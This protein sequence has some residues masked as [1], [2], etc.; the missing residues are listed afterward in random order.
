[1]RIFDSVI[2]NSDTDYEEQIETLNDRLEQGTNIL[3]VLQNPPDPSSEE[4]KLAKTLDI[5][6]Q[7]ELEHIV[8]DMAMALLGKEIDINN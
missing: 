3:E 6:L 7:E 1:M 5:N 4:A 8:E 2:H